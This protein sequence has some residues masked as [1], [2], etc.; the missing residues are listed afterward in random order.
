[1]NK[2][3]RTIL[4]ILAILL[5]LIGVGPFLVPVP[6]LEN[7]VPPQALAD[8]DSHFIE[9]KGQMLHYKVYGAGEPVFILLHGFASN[10]YTWHKIVP[11]LAQ[12]GTVLLYDRI[13]FGLSARPLTWEGDNPYTREAQV[14]QTISLMNA[15]ALDQAILVGNSAG[16]TV[17]ADIA[18]AYPERVQALILVDAAIYTG[19]G[20]PDFVK[21]LLRTPQMRHLGPLISRSFLAQGGSLLDLAW[22]DPS[23]ITAEDIASYE[24]PLQVENW[25]KS[26]WEFTLASTASD[27]P[28]RLDE[29]TLPV[30]V[31]TGDDDRI[32]PTAESQRLANELVNAELVIIPDC[33]HVP[34]EE[35]PALFLDAVITFVAG[36]PG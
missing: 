8:P 14:E 33:G 31:I 22:H 20:A 27:L 17:S 18:L 15:L 28:D 32:V 12:H 10:T 35:Q 19:G 24:K 2:R 21:P 26:L 1:M 25:D 11:E 30:L 3:R 23:R 13:G 7:S 9:V 34:Q 16:G 36:L 5:L 4:I 6:D 29:L